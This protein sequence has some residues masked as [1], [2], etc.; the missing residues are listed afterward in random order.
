[1]HTLFRWLAAA[2]LL[3]ISAAPAFSPAPQ[4]TPGEVVAL[5]NAYRAEFGLPP[6]E[7]H[8]LLSQ[9]AQGQA[10]YLAS[11]SGATGGDIHTG[12]G[13]TR[14]RDRAYAAGYGGGS[15]IFISEI[16]KYGMG[17]T[18]QSAIGWWK[19]S[20]NH[21]PTMIASTYVH[22]GCGVATDGT[23]RYYF[24]CVTG[25]S[26]GGGSGTGSSGGSTPASGQ[27]QVPPVQIMIPVTKAEPQPDGSIVHILRTGQT[28]WTLAAVYDVPLQQILDLNAYAEWEVVHP[29]DEVIVAPPGS[30]PTSAP[31]E[32]PNATPSPTPTLTPSP[33]PTATV[34]SA[35]DT[36]ATVQAALAQAQEVVAQ[37]AAAQNNS[38]GSVQLV[39]GVA[40]ISILSVVVASFFIQRPSSE[41][42]LD[43]NDPFAPIT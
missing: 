2:S 27:S 35:A 36:D 33:Q 12:P 3:L 34:L 39:V 7:E 43:E 28:L 38:N 19:Q 26:V 1:M 15:T 4:G 20:P 10:D 8:S 32:D 21:N 41:P 37:Q 14:P 9:L 16:A 13:G 5:I 30:V 29:G 25:Y 40:L 18:S 22:I 24:V 17:E 42:D 6:Y 23:T 31:T 11:T